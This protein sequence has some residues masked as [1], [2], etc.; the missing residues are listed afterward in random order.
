MQIIDIQSVGFEDVDVQ[1]VEIFPEMWSRRKEFTRYRALP[2]P[3]GALFFICTDIRASFYPEQ[4]DTVTGGK[5]DVIYI[6]KGI[7]YRASVS[8]TQN[9]IDTYTVNFTL[10][11]NEEMLLCDHITKLAA[12]GDDRFIPAAEQLHRAVYHFEE[13]G[14]HNYVKIK[15]AFFSLLDLVADTAAAQKDIYYPIRPGVR[16]LQSQWNQNIK[17]EDYAALCGISPAYFYKCFKAW[18]G[19]S[20]VEYRNLLRLTNA[21]TLLC[22]TDMPVGEI[23]EMV[24]FSDPFYFCRVFTKHFALSPQQYRRS[25]K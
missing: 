16:A 2:R 18:S 7:C 3:T 20:P 12:C 19:K 4:G 17:V 21:A 25:R 8:G 15:S 5:G 10:F 13:K 23:A 9:C 24:G 6:P 14:R 1:G 11:G 22:R